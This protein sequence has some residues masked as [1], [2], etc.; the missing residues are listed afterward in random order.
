M[1]NICIYGDEC[2]D[3]AFLRWNIFTSYDDCAV[4]SEHDHSID[5][6]VKID[7]TP[8]R[9]GEN[10][11]INLPK[12]HIYLPSK[13]YD[14]RQPASQ[15]V[16]KCSSNK[17]TFCR[18]QQQASNTALATCNSSVVGSRSPTTTAT[19]AAQQYIQH[20]QAADVGQ[21][22]IFP[23][24]LSLTDEGWHSWAYDTRYKVWI[25]YRQLKNCMHIISRVHTKILSMF[26][27]QV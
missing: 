10:Y 15:S 26:M 3:F 17:A 24:R 19:T 23:P 21:P 1:L 14:W 22:I 12:S 4:Q 7:I 18:R 20:T 5:C 9:I 8:P 6:A 25:I 27:Y 13:I 16:K 2:C 11:C